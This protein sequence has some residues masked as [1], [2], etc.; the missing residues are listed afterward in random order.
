M[1]LHASRPQTTKCGDASACLNG[2][3]TPLTRRNLGFPYYKPRAS[4]EVDGKHPP[5]VLAERLTS[6]SVTR[7]GRLCRTLPSDEVFA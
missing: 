5:R 7:R 2:F 4:H 3:R 6:G 1:R